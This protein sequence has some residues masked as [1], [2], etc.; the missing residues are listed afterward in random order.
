MTTYDPSQPRQ[1]G[2][3]A[4]KAVTVDGRASAPSPSADEPI[5]LGPLWSVCYIADNED[6]A[7]EQAFRQIA[8]YEGRQV[9][10]ERLTGTLP[11]GGW[12]DLW[13]EGTAAVTVIGML[14]CGE[15]DDGGMIP[16]WE[17]RPVDPDATVTVREGSGTRQIRLGDVA[18][19]A[20]YAPGIGTREG[21]GHRTDV[22]FIE[23]EPT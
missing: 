5:S 3:F 11:D 16:E 17:V 19:L 20:Y 6:Q 2:R 7:R 23:P 1:S 21:F 15:W 18:D 10:A 14:D 22:T 4:E 9:L 12:D 13:L 8:P